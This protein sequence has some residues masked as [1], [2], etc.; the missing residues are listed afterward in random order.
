MAKLRLDGR[1]LFRCQTQLPSGVLLSRNIVHVVPLSLVLNQG[2][3]RQWHGLMR[4]P[5]MQWG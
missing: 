4:V 1:F 2:R 5:P 3:E